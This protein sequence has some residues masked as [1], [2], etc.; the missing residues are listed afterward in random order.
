[1]RFLTE[2]NLKKGDLIFSSPFFSLA[3]RKETKNT[4]IKK[5]SKKDSYAT[6][7]NEVMSAFVML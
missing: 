2:G 5:V 6:C 1:L 4:A 3:Q 7:C